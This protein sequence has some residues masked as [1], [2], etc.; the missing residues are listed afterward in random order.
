MTPEDHSGGPVRCE[1]LG[2]FVDGELSAEEAAV[3]RRHLLIC[4]RCQQEMHGL[5]Q[6]SALA[7]Q[8]R[9]QRP[10]E[11][12]DIA[13]VVAALDRRAR[14]RRAA[15]M[16]VV[17]AVAI[18]AALVLAIR[19][20]SSGPNMPTLLASLDARTVSGWP[21]AAGPGQYKEYRVMRGG[22]VS[23]PPG[24]AQ[25]ELR[26]QGS[27]DWR[28][29]GTLA[30]LRRDFTQADAYLALLPPTQD[31]SGSRSNTT[32]RRSSTSTRR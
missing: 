16:G 6:L 21:S 17:G 8:A 15:W 26:L 14:P 24:L 11:R 2:A 27:S 13:P 20:R 28:S 7:E 25:A 9:V 4:A 18:A 10:A 29:L 30:L 1:Q 31:W 12:P 5:M 3:F 32:R 22:P 23:I 19:G